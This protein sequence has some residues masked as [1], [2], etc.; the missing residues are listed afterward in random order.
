MYGDQFGEFVFGYWDLRVKVHYAVGSDFRIF[1]HL[2]VVLLET[3]ARLAQL[4][5]R[6]SAEREAAGSSPGRFNTQGL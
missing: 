1:V 6:R 5:K 2:S 3:A 4:L